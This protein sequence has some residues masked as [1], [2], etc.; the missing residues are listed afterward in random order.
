MNP[1][2]A[3]RVG[4]RAAEYGR[5]C[6]LLGRE[7][8]DVELDLFGVMW[9]EHCSYKTSRP[10]LRLLPVSGPDVLQGPGENAGIVDIGGGLAV[11]MKVESHNHP[12][13]VEPYQGAATGSGGIIRDIFTMGARPV[14]M[15]DS[16]RF[17]NLDDACQRA[18]FRGVVRGIGDYDNCMGIPTV[19]GE[20]GFDP[21]YAGNCLVNAMCVG[22]IRHEEIKRGA[23]AGVG[24]AVMLVGST[25]GRDGMGG[26]SFASVDLT[27][28]SQ[29]RKSA[30]QVGDPF[31]EKLLLEA[32]LELFQTDAVVGIQDLGAA[33]LTSASCET[34]ARGGVGIDLDVALV[35]RREEGMVASE[36]MISES[37][38]RMLVIVRQG[39]EDDVCRIFA[40]WGLNAAVIGRVT[41]DGMLTVRQDGDIVAQVPAKALAEQAPLR[42]PQAER[43]AWQD[44]VMRLDATA[45]PDVAD[46]TAV[47]TSVLRTPTVA[48][49]EWVYRQYD[50]VVR[51]STVV[52][53][54]S[55]AAVLRVDG[56]VRGIALTID[57]TGP[58]SLL[59][60]ATGAAMAVAEAARN[61][62]C[63]GAR[64][65]A[66]TD[67]L[68][69]G[70]PERPDVFWQFSEA[71]A[72][73]SEA[74]RALG[75]PVIGGNVSFYNETGTSAILPTPVVGMV[76]IMDDLSHVCR[77]GFIAPGDG[78]VLLGDCTEEL[79]GS[80]YVHLMTGRT[81]GHVP[82]LDLERERLVQMVCLDGIAHGIIRSAHDVSEGGLAVTLAESCIAGDTGAAVSLPGGGRLD[83]LLFG[84]APSRIVVS[85]APDDLDTLLALARKVGVPATLLGHVAGSDLTIEAG[86]QPV[87]RAPVAELAAAWRGALPGVMSR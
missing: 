58:M 5:V 72:G 41:T 38:E 34:A 46:W 1:V 69:F 74:C 73:M 77:Q 61:L 3:E 68:N 49:K 26:A 87:V 83:A 25:T 6:E 82:I 17:G 79:G 59:D 66:L 18:L 42:H 86:A 70:N 45:L 22:I 67:C 2:R 47:L 65:L 37:Q 13:A 76:G 4:L 50:S 78:I 23:A 15:L 36:V 12:S 60:P 8:G 21:S 30:V 48:C 20:V 56:T 19:A 43:P 84:E 40:K 24:N 27:A 57:G 14:A 52:G 31:M 71:V 39:R 85:V 55:D 62:V 33:G 7:P 44:E 54:G 53:P 75:I 81:A 32:C 16:L 51:T 11:V 35:P 80:V 9:S 29:E 64:P 63:S 28:A 10:L